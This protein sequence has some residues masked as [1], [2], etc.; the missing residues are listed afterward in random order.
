MR[1]PTPNVSVVD[2]VANVEQ[3]TSVED[4][5][6]ALKHASENSLKG[7]LGYE[8]QELVSTD[9]RGTTVRLSS[10]RR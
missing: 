3:L 7:I 4:V 5:N 9:Y 1:V 8:S 6:R 2:L 10:T